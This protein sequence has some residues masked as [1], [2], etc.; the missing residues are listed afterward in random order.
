MRFNLI[1]YVGRDG[2]AKAEI[3]S[4]ETYNRINRLPMAVANEGPNATAPRI[5]TTEP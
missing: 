4:R 2:K 3:V 5:R 1:I